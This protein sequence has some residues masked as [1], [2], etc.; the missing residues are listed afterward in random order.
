MMTLE[1]LV[2]IIAVIIAYLIIVERQEINF[3]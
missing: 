3:H 2:G 1:T